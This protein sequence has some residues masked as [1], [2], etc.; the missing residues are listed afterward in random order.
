MTETEITAG[1]SDIHHIGK[2]TVLPAFSQV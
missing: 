2:D 1:K